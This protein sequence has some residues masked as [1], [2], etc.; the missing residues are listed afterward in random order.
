MRFKI[1][2]TFIFFASL[3][4]RGAT[5]SVALSGVASSFG[6]PH[7]YYYT[8]S[9]QTFT[10]PAGTT[11]IMF[12]VWGAGGGGSGNESGVGGSGGFAQGI[13]TVTPGTVYKI[14]VGQGGSATSSTVFGGGAGG[15]F[16]S[17]YEPANAGSGGGLSGVFLSSYTFANAIIVAGGGGGSGKC[18]GT[19][20]GGGGGL[21]GNTGPG[22]GSPEGGGTGGTQSSGGV[23]SGTGVS[24]GQLAGGMGGSEGAGGGGGGY[25]GGG[26]GAGTCSSGGGGSAYLHGSLSGTTTLVGTD[27]NS[28]ASAVPKYTDP[29]YKPGIGNGGPTAGTAGHGLVVLIY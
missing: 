14:I 22:R 10:V 12:K 1:F 23:A 21:V 25:Y 2:F 6:S 16:R 29:D 3:W 28:A 4:T 18:G 7:F 15:T 13:L 26:G 19:T 17:S 5:T 27:G 9:Q 20:G 11:S 24:G 8:G